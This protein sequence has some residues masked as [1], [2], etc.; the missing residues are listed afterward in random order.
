MKAVVQDRYGAP[1]VLELRDVEQPVPGDDEVLVRVRAAGLNAYDWH[2]MRGDP[3][4][5]RLALGPRAPRARIRGR[6]FAGEV[7]AVGRNVSGLRPG[8]EVFGEVDGTFAEY[9]SVPD[10]WVERKPASLTFEQAAAL[11]LAGSTAL[12]GLR[13]VAELRPGQRVLVNGASGGVGT[14]AVQIAKALGAEVTGVCST[15]NT[16]LVRSLGADHVV[17]YT[18][19][20][21]TRAGRRYDVVLDLAASQSLS[22]LR[23]AL[24]PTGTLVLGSGGRSGQFFGAPVLI[25]QGVALS[26]LVRQ[27]LRPLVGPA[28]SKEVLADLRELADSGKLAPVIDRTYPLDEA[29]EAIRYLEEEHARG[30][31]VVTV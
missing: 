7:A 16:G 10:A 19:E 11:P 2:L 6:D 22:G 28:P 15:R 25:L 17:D 5:A 14:F 21:F 29:P 20:D 27:R 13:D 9:V 23:R 18:R 3:Y 31:V 4:V 26:P 1:D 24:T 30:K 12:R 8:D